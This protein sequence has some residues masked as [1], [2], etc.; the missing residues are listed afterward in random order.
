MASPNYCGDYLPQR[1]QRQYSY[2]EM[3]KVIRSVRDNVISSAFGDR[4]MLSTCGNTIIIS[5]YNSTDHLCNNKVMDIG[6][7][8]MEYSDLWS[9]KE[10]QDRV[11]N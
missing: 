2:S 6:G 9:G 11:C 5:L 1:R 3:Q 8:R 10:F 4:E 7:G